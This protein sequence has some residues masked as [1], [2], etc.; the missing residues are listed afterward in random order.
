MLLQLLGD[1]LVTYSLP[2]EKVNSIVSRSWAGIEALCDN[3]LYKLAL[4]FTVYFAN[5]QL[6]KISR[7]SRV[8]ASVQ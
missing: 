7:F 2:K 6:K 4:T 8:Y 1:V 5:T 3:A